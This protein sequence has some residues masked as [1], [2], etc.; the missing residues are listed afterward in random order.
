MAG[1][2]DGPGLRAWRFPVERSTTQ[3]EQD[4]RMLREALYGLTAQDRWVSSVWGYDG[5]GCALSEAI[6]KLPGFYPAAAERQIMSRRAATIASHARPVTLV[7]LGCGSGVIRG[8][9]VEALL[10]VGTLRRYAGIDVSEAALLRAGDQLAADF[11]QLDGHGLLGDFTYGLPPGAA[12]A[13]P[14]L[15]AFL[16]NSIGRFTRAERLAFLDQVSAMMQPDDLLLVSVDLVQDP[17]TAVS[18]YDD[19]VGV[20][21]AFNKNVLSVLNRRLRADFQ[22]RAFDHLVSWNEDAARVEVGLR[23]RRVQTVMVGALGVRLHFA[24]GD[25]LRTCSS[26]RFSHE[27]FAGEL[28]AAGL[29]PERCFTDPHSRFNAYL[30]RADRSGPRFT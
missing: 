19:E 24:P 20:A 12:G 28:E 10:E 22:P 26:A 23:S 11:P 3:E 16:G 18:A 5:L 1:S 25:V 30:A 9:L 6:S 4:E 15:L 7:E 2:S 17:P 13:G 27:V 8:T 29:I 14:R 21:G